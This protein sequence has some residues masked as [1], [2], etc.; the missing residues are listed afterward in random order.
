LGKYIRPQNIFGPD[1]TRR[2]LVFC[3][4]IAICH[5]R[6]FGQVWGPG[7]PI[8]SRRKTTRPEGTPL[9]LRLPH[10]KLV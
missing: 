8:R 3:M 6:K 5:R 4:G 9:D 7:S 1:L 10:G 2:V